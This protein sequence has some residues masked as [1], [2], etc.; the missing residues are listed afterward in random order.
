MQKISGILRKL[1]KHEKAPVLI[2]GAYLVG[3]D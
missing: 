3:R 1:N 2:A